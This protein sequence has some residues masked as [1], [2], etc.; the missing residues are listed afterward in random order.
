METLV[1]QSRFLHQLVMDRSTSEA[2]GRVETPWMDPAVHRVL[3][4]VCKPQGWGTRRAVFSLPQIH[5]LGE[6][7]IVLRSPATPATLAQV[8]QLESL[9]HLAVWSEAGEFIGHLQDCVFNLRTG[10]VVAYLMVPDGWQRFTGT[11]YQIA[12]TQIISYSP[13]QVMLTE[14]AAQNL[15]VYEPGVDQR[16]RDVSQHLRSD[17]STEWRSLSERARTLAATAKERW[18]GLTQQVSEQAREVV[19]QASET[20]QAWKQ[21]VQ[22]QFQTQWLVDPTADRKDPAAEA[23]APVQ[24]IVLDDLD[25]DAAEDEELDWDWAPAPPP[26]SPQPEPP[27]RPPSPPFTAAPEA[28]TRDPETWDNEDWDGEEW[29]DDWDAASPPPAPRRAEQPSGTSE[30]APSEVDPSPVPLQLDP[31]VSPSRSATPPPDREDEPWI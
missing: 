26:A 16:L 31:T 6:E 28:G 10:R 3:G 12:P 18:S 14:T 2:I 9:L 17:A 1:R 22:D 5:T 27:R 21:Y 7:S 15:A 24:E 4:F 23:T 13:E 20:A 19:G 29:D 11:I 8:Q 30:A 25:W